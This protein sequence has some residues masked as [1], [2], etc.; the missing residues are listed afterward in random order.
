MHRHR[1]LVAGALGAGGYLVGGW[2]LVSRLAAG[3]TDPID[4]PAR[5]TSPV[6][7]SAHAPAAPPVE[8][9][10]RELKVLI[11]S[12][13]DGPVYSCLVP[14]HLVSADEIVVTSRDFDSIRRLHD[15][16]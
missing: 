14:A 13:V 11:V 6:L 15:C 16:V 8:R 5:A 7:T 2:L 1:R 3:A 9:V 10:A 12:V 4:Q